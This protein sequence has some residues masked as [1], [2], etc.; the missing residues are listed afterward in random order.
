MNKPSKSSSKSLKVVKGKSMPKQ[1][2]S[3]SLSK[4]S[5]SELNQSN[6]VISYAE[7]RKQT[8]SPSLSKD[9]KS[10]LN[11]VISDA[12]DNFNATLHDIQSKYDVEHKN[13]EEVINITTSAAFE[14]QKNLCS[15]LN[16]KNS[17]LT[18]TNTAEKQQA[19]YHE[20]EKGL[21]T[22]KE[23]SMININ[24]S[25]NEALKRINE[26]KKNMF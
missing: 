7:E 8:Q 13:I 6:K 5:N 2:Q 16:I 22:L 17:I 10:Q 21:A 24:A 3:V 11:K 18:L 1:T 26:D 19:F 14:H 15:F 9:S 4:D 23:I 20:N 12:E 25:I